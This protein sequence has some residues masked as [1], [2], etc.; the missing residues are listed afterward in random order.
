VR[1]RERQREKHRERERQRERERE[2]ERFWG[3]A[4]ICCLK[5]LQK[6]C[7]PLEGTTNLAKKL[8]IGEILSPD[9][10]KITSRQDDNFI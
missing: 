6:E 8:L 3:E 7:F 1:E 4:V 9:P 2:R 10:G 5:D